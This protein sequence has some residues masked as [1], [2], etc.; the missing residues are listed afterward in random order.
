MQHGEVVADRYELTE[1]LGSGGMAWVWR[2]TDHRL[3]RSVAVKFVKPE[4]SE[5]PEFLVRFFSEAQAVARINHHNVV[6]VLDFGRHDERPYLVMEHVG[7]GSAADL[8]GAPMLPERALEIVEGA[9]RGAG[10][11]HATG[12]VHRDIKPANI[13]IDET[14]NT[15]LADFGIATLAGSENLTGTGQAIGSPHYISPEHV[16]GRTTTPASDVYS[17]GIVLYELL[18]GRRPFD[19]SSVTAIAIAHVEEEPVPPSHLV[20]DLDPGLDALVLQCLAKDPEDRWAD[21]NELADMIASGVYLEGGVAPIPT[22]AAGPEP[23]VRRLDRKVLAA[24][25]TGV[26]LAGGLWLGYSVLGKEDRAVSAPRAPKSQSPQTKR[27]RARSR[28]T[29]TPAGTVDAPVTGTSPE[30]E[31]EDDAAKSQEG[32]GGSENGAPTPEPTVD[33][34]PT[35][36]PSVTPTPEPTSTSGSSEDNPTTG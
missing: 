9:A 10:A 14:G 1:P 29:P 23:L 19:S 3:D 30:P 28:P 6:Q 27:A 11:A 34:T 17:L 32:G 2:A 5:N 18:C 12:L 20:D 21:G 35:P 13:L 22:P 33:V 36:E 8:T 4:F 16:S 31:D 7:G 15:K 24:V 25:M 26:L